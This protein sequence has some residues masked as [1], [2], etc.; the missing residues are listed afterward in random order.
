MFFTAKKLD[1]CAQIVGEGGIGVILLLLMM[2]MMVVVVLIMVIVMVMVMMTLM[3]MMMLMTKVIFP[4]WGWLR[5]MIHESFPCLIT[6][7]TVYRGIL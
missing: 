2:M 1:R 6:I 5:Q 7:C 4:Q 3:M